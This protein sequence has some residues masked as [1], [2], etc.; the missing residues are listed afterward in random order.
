[1][2]KILIVAPPPIQRPKGPIAVK[3]KGVEKKTDLA[4]EIEK[5]ANETGCAFFN[6]GSVTTTSKIDGVHLD[7][8]QHL[9]L[10]IT[11][12]KNVKPMLAFKRSE[13]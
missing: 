13:N 8:E 12:A 4:S 7:V 9:I 3:L 11:M 2:P 10:D 6:A 5:V 1:M